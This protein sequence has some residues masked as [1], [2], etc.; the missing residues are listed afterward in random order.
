M[1][2]LQIVRKACIEANPEIVVNENA[3]LIHQDHTVEYFVQTRP[4]RLADV[5]LAIEL[6]DKKDEYGNELTLEI[7]HFGMFVGSVYNW[8]DEPV[9]W[10]LKNDTLESQSPETLSFLASLLQPKQ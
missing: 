4:I 5:L 10:Q 3:Q 8:E 2:D 1:T 6:K 9:F 7:T